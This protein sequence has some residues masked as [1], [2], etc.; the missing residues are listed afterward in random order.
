MREKRALLTMERSFAARPDSA[1]PRAERMILGVARKLRCGE[2]RLTLPSGHSETITGPERGPAA[3]LQIR[4]N[5]FFKKLFT[6]GSNGFA[7]AYMEGDCDTP[8]LSA[9]L[10]LAASNADSIESAIEGHW[11]SRALNRAYHLLRPN[12][13]GG[14]KRNIRAHYDLGNDF[15]ETWL[16]PSMTYSSAIFERPEMP[17]EEAQEAKYR[18]LAESARIESGHSVLEIGCGWGGF[19][20]WAAREI[21][22]KVTAITISD[23]QYAFAAERLQ[24]EGVSDR[25]TLLRQDYRDTRGSFDR[26]ASIEMF[27]AVGETYWPQYFNTL[28][29]NLKP[30]GQAGLQIITIADQVFD[31]Y[32][33]SADFIQRYIFPGGMLP[34]LSALDRQV[35]EAGL[36]WIRNS[37]YGE[38]YAYTL[39]QW[40]ERFEEAWPTLPQGRFDERF[41]RMWKYYLSYC[42]AGFATGRIDVQQIA[43]ARD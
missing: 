6:G 40:H 18:K 26:I 14:S 32:R 22:C 16:D 29:E 11:W 38:H 25:V 9:F 23:A 24:R 3:E 10:I 31:S 34:S 42:E 19:A 39:K 7:E 5:L 30:G 13:R 28:R 15:Y 12:T 37:G 20:S 43:L 1:L 21:G 33:R 41:R 2:L 27:E 4:S 17:L 36:S 8:D 35:R